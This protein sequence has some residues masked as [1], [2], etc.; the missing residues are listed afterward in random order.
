MKMKTSNTKMAKKAHSK[1]ASKAASNAASKRRPAAKKTVVSRSAAQY[2]VCK[3]GI[4][5]DRRI[6]KHPI[7]HHRNSKH[8][9][10]KQ[11]YYFLCCKSKKLYPV[12][13]KRQFLAMKDRLGYLINVTFTCQVRNEMQE[14]STFPGIFFFKKIS[15]KYILNNPSEAK[16]DG[17]SLQCPFMFQSLLDFSPCMDMEV[18]N[19]EGSVNMKRFEKY[20]ETCKLNIE[21][22][23]RKQPELK[24]YK[25]TYENLLKKYYTTQGADVDVFSMVFYVE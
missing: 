5:A 9:H 14:M 20:I 24:A 7:R 25:D 16:F 2:Q 8:H 22:E 19:K 17:I 1:T 15:K 10:R 18:K 23:F 13:Y 11:V 12:V 21:K 3:N 6:I 4:C